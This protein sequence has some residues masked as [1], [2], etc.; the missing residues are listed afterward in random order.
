MQARGLTYK[1]GQA[2]FDIRVKQGANSRIIESLTL[3]MPGDHNV[4][5][6]L[7]AVAVG[8]ELGMSDTDIRAALAGFQGVGRRFTRV[9][10]VD[11][12]TI[13]NDYGHRPVE[14]AAVLKA[15]RQSVEPGARVIAVHQPHRYSRLHALFADFTTCFAGADVVAIAEV[16]AAGEDPVPGADRDTLVAAIQ[17]QGHPSATAI[18]SAED[19]AALVLREAKSGDIVVCLGA[20]TIS[21]W[22]QGLPAQLAKP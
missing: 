15:A 19:L 10:E 18:G 2:H 17:A 4:S 22:A 14:I 8:L 3:P 5:N 20:G 11:G 16:Y 6:A 12:V 9:G 1:K 13:I 21:A 7:S